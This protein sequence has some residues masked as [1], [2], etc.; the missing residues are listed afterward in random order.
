MMI[1]M[2]EKKLLAQNSGADISPGDV[3]AVALCL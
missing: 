2:N 3:F 1:G